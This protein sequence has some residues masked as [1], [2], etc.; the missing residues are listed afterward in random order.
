MLDKFKTAFVLFFITAL[1]GFAIYYVNEFTKDTIFEKRQV[2]EENYYRDIFGLEE[3]DL[4]NI[5]KVDVNDGIDQEIAINDADGN[6]L[7]Y[8]YKSRERNSYGVIEVLVG[9]NPDGNIS[10]VVIANSTNT[11][12]FVKKVKDFYLEPF[13]GQTTDG[14]TYDSGTGASFTYGSVSKFVDYSVTYFE[15]NRGGQDD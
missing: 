4:I 2:Q 6:L 10:K 7:G 15:V 12:T 14:V 9:I 8:I 3:S 1:S 13:I 5:S 11:P